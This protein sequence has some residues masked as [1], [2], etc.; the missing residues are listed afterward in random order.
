M[1]S[2]HRWLCILSITVLLALLVTALVLPSPC[3]VP[4]PCARADA[5]SSALSAPAPLVPD[6][7]PCHACAQRMP[8]CP[9]ASRPQHQSKLCLPNTHAP[10]APCPVH[11]AGSA[12]NIA[13]SAPLSTAHLSSPP[14]PVPMCYAY[15]CTQQSPCSPATLVPQHAMPCHASGLRAWLPLLSLLPCHACLKRIH[16]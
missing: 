10:C 11:I 15:P 4:M 3:P 2:V 7:M 8:P 14:C 13:V 16:P 5:P 1:P 12:S 9:H 6:A